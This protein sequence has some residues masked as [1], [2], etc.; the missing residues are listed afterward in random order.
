MNESEPQMTCRKAIR[1]YQNQGALLPWDKLAGHLCYCASGIRHGSGMNSFQALVRNLGI[2]VERGFVQ[3]RDGVPRSSAKE[4]QAMTDK[5]W[6]I[7]K[8]T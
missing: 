5:Q 8:E 4:V 3:R 1:R 6:M 2:C 7:L